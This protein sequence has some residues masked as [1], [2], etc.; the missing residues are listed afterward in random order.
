MSGEREHPAYFSV[1]RT[2]KRSCP[3]VLP[4]RR[5][6]LI[7][8][9]L[10]L[11]APSLA[12]AKRAEAAKVEPVIYGGVRYA[13][14]NDNGRRGYIQ[15]WDTKTETKLCELTVYRKFINPFLEEDVQW[16]FIKKLSVEDGWLKVIDERDREYGVNLKTRMV[17][18]LK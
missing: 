13:A 2:M 6:A 3:F 17:K 10:V 14:P 12:F 1:K 8:A 7:L 16:V 4:W 11:L 5:I 18:R 15:A 9:C